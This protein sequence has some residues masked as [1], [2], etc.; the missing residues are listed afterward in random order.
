MFIKYIFVWMLLAVVAIINGIIRV[1]TYGQIMPELAAHQ[2]STLTA[3]VASAVVIW[4]ANR[5]WP[6]TT[7]TEAWS[8][9]LCWLLMTM[10]FEFGFGHYVAGHAWERLLADY[11][12]LRGR[13]WPLFL[14]WITVAPFVMHKLAGAIPGRR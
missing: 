4:L 11:N 10:A 9:G 6:I 13:V 7:A 5:R 12:L 14:G 1:S 2:L 8:I 3:V